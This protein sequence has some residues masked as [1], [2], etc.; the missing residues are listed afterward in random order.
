MSNSGQLNNLPLLL[1]YALLCG[2]AK[3]QQQQG[4]TMALALTNQRTNNNTKEE[5][6][7]EEVNQGQ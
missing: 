6:K 1:Q 2:P 4:V 5:P 7:Q 3:Q